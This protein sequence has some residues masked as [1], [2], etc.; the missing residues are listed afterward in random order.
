M[1]SVCAHLLCTSSEEDISVQLRLLFLHVL[2]KSSM[3]ISKISHFFLIVLSFKGL[4]FGGYPP[5]KKKTSPW[6]VG[7][8][9]LSHS[10]ARISMFSSCFKKELTRGN[11]TWQLNRNQ[12]LK[13]KNPTQPHFT[14]VRWKLETWSSPLPQTHVARFL[15]SVLIGKWSLNTRNLIRGRWMRFGLNSKQVSNVKSYR[16]VLIK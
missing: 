2:S 5:P 1:F 4:I 14:Y 7:N 3:S 10:Y 9:K 8:L 16:Q 15:P 6:W 11:R 12:V 13:S